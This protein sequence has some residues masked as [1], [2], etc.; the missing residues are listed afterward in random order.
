MFLETFLNQICATGLTRLAEKYCIIHHIQSYFT[1]LFF[2][3]ALLSSLGSGSVRIGYTD[4]SRPLERCLE[5]GCYGRRHF[6]L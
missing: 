5:S 1:W 6:S 2:S 4:G 3:A